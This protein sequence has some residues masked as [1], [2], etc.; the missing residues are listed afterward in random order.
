[1]LPNR[2]KRLARQIRREMNEIIRDNISFGTKVIF[3]ITDVS[4]SADYKNCKIFYSLM[5]FG[6]AAAERVERDVSRELEE[7]STSFKFIL[8]KHMRI[9]NVPDLS[10][11][12]DRTPAKAAEVEKILSEIFEDEK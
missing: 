1:M 8:G 4:L 6:D 3:T 12:I 9:R 5:V 2:N 7:K 10:F 11:Y